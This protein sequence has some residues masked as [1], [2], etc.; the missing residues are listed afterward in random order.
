MA[1]PGELSPHPTL[2]EHNR[3]GYSP[4]LDG[5]RGVAVLAVVGTHQHL[6][7]LR[8]G[9]FGVDIF[10]A[11]SGF[12]ITTLLLEDYAQR[13]SISLRTFFV[14]RFFRLYPAFVVLVA[15]SALSSILRNEVGLDRVALVVASTLAYQSNWLFIADPHSWIGGLGHTWSL[16]VEV[17]FYL[18]WAVTLAWAVRRWGLRLQH[19]LVF[20]LAVAAVSEL[21]RIIVW[22]TT[23]HPAHAYSGTDT[24]LDSLFLGVAAAL[25]R[26]QYLAD[27][28]ANPILRLTRWGVRCLELAL[29]LGVA[30]LLHDTPRIAPLAFLGGFG[31]VGGATALLILTTLLSPHSILSR[32]LQTG[33]LVWFGQISYSLYLW[34]QPVTKLLTA[35][36]LARF[37]Q[38]AWFIDVV[39]FAVSVALAVVSYYGV[40]RVFLRRRPSLPAPQKNP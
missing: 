36:R 5:I 31:L 33:L 11:L 34:N 38:G 26:F 15:I 16:A 37:G 2:R 39:R 28:A 12:L 19:L 21:W 8:G 13:G 30:W 29:A 22:A 7:W 14:R 10:F 20:A 6:D 32:P 17:H 24:R 4:T 23:T 9:Y 1:I 35:E 18:I 27:P 3:L 25:I 40:E